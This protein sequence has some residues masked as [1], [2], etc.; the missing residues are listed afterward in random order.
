MMY[1]HEVWIYRV[2]T[3]KLRLLIVLFYQSAVFFILKGAESKEGAINQYNFFYRPFF[4]NVTTQIGKP[5]WKAVSANQ[6]KIAI[7]GDNVTKFIDFV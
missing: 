4:C 1:V 6:E 7:F 5:V 3:Q 2:R